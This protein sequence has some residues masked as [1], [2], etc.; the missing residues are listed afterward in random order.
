MVNQIIKC[1]RD[2][3]YNL[4]ENWHFMQLEKNFANGLPEEAVGNILAL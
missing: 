3:V 2:I 1:K 4:G